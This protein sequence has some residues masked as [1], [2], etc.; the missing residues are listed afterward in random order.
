MTLYFRD[1]LSDPWGLNNKELIFEDQGQSQVIT[2][3]VAV[4]MSNSPYAPD[5]L[6]EAEAKL[7]QLPTALYVVLEQRVIELNKVANRELLFFQSLNQ[8]QHWTALERALPLSEQYLIAQI[9][10]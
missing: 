7:Y 8:G 1:N 4:L 10:S 2:S 9:Q 6:H 5:A 3:V